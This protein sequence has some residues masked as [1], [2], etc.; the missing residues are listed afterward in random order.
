L[1]GVLS[2]HAKNATLAAE[3]QSMINA[4]KLYRE[5]REPPSREAVAEAKAI[6]AGTGTSEGEGANK[7]IKLSVHPLFSHLVDA[8]EEAAS[9][10]IN[11]LRGFRPQAVR[12][13]SSIV[14]I[15]SGIDGAIVIQLTW[16][17]GFLRS[18]DNFGS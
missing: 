12:R 3:Y 4:T 9:D 10:F 18:V 5:T 11:K 8:A 2:D 7:M 14:N 13:F 1:E 16:F 15:G 6:L 17:F